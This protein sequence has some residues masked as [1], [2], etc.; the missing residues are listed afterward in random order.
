MQGNCEPARDIQIK[1]KV[2]SNAPNKQLTWINISDNGEFDTYEF[3]PNP[4]PSSYFTT[5]INRINL[6]TQCHPYLM[7]GT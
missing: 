2:T 7:L 5:R 6:G 1:L 4:R 3:Y